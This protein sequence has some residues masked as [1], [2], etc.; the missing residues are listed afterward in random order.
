MR[1]DRLISI[2]MYLQAR[3]RMTAAE[4]ARE[5]EV[6]E[7]TIYR[8]L[9]ALHA[10]GVPVLAERGP[11]G[12]VELPENYRTNLTGFSEEEVRGLFLSAV[13][14]PLADLG[15]GKSIEGAVLKLTAALPEAH[16]HDIEQVRARI[17]VDTSDWFRPGEQVPFLELLQRAVWQDRRVM[18]TYAPAV[19]RKMRTCIEPYGLVAKGTVWYVVASPVNSAPVFGVT[20]VKAARRTTTA[21]RIS[22]IHEAELQDEQFERP[23]GFD[24]REYWDN[25]VREFRESM[26]RYT[27]TVRMDADLLNRLPRFL[28]EGARGLAE[29]AG[30]P[31]EGGCV[32]LDLTFDSFEGARGAIMSLGAGAEVLA[33]EELRAGVLDLASDLLDLYT[34]E[35]R[36]RDHRVRYPERFEQF[37]WR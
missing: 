35:G 11:G 26:P 9:E 33:P 3:G 24:L 17:H 7:R 27:A 22:R 1:A 4:L 20:K 25:W 2:M 34:R 32:V 15:L 8:D 21:Y 23:E 16:R 18:M 14:G 37:E 30:P 5:L 29:Q 13:P 12:G 31:D 28:G 36:E 19:G 10:S 6:S